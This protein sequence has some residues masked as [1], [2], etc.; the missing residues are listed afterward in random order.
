METP[1]QP[2]PA[3]PVS[4]IKHRVK[5][6]LPV[7]DEAR[8]RNRSRVIELSRFLVKTFTKVTVSGM[9]NVPMQG[10]A[11]LVVNHLGDAD[12]VVKIA[13]FPRQIDP[14]AKI[15]LNDIPILGTIM[16]SY[17]VIWIRRG[18]P[19]RQALSAALRGLSEGRLIMI[20]PEG[21]ESS[22]G[23]LE[24][25]LNG[26]AFLAIK[27]GAPVLPVAMTGTENSRIYPNMLRF[28]RTEVSLAVGP[29]FWLP[30]DLDRHSAIT[31]GTQIIMQAIADLLP[32]EYRGVYS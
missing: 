30:T 2:I 7:L 11:L 5:I 28:Q 29:L 4:S 1:D 19:D 20:N 6:E 27:A 13:N 10:P 9:E 21:R 3:K 22:T 31:R 18:Q 25:A 16:R 8:L 26:A 17:G 15:E 32:V 12:S 24:E 23:A 14:I